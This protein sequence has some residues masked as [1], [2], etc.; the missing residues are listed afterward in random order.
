MELNEQ[1]TYLPYVLGLFFGVGSR[2]AK[3]NPQSHKH[4]HQK[5]IL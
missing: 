5:P 2:T 4:L 1:S 3:R